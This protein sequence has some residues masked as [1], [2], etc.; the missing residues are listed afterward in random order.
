[1]VVRNPHH[2]DIDPAYA[3]WIQELHSNLSQWTAWWS[4]VWITNGLNLLIDL[5][6]M[7]AYECPSGSSLQSHLVGRLTG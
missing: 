5:K 4:H 6:E 3:V 7:L 1:M 2:R